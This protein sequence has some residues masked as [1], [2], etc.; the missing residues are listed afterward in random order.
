VVVVTLGDKG[1]E[2]HFQGRPVWRIPAHTV[3]SN[4]LDVSGAGDTF[5]AA[6]SLAIFNNATPVEA[7]KIGTV[8][9]GL[10]VGST[11]R[12]R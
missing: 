9:S 8:S 5:L 6:F 11:A 3:T 10:V 7:D 2:V 4:E 12:R 1:C